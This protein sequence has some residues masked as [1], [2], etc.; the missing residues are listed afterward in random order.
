MAAFP[1]FDPYAVLAERGNRNRGGTPANSARPAKVEG[2]E[3]GTL[4]TLAGLAAA[5]PELENPLREHEPEAKAEPA[6][7][8]LIA[9]WFGRDPAADEPPYDHPCSAR[10][11]VIRRPR[12]RFEH[13]CAV[14][15]AW[16]GF[17]YGVA[18]AQPGR[19]YCLAHRPDA[20]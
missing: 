12:G 2:A 5:P 13:F 14:C 17:G 9:P 16:G 4:A 19:W 6:P 20:P 1:R 10:R 18:G 8:T 7:A 15:G 11:G 3:A